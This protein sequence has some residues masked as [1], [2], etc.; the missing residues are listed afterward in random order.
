MKKSL[1]FVAAVLLV[2]GAGAQLRDYKVHKRGMLHQSVFNTGELGRAYD[3]GQGGSAAGVPS[4]E[5]PGYSSVI[6][7]NVSYNGQ[8]HSF[9]AGIYLAVSR[10]DTSSRLFSHCGAVEEPVAGRYAFPLQL[11]RVE[12]YPVLP[13]GELN[14]AFNPDEAEEIITAKWATNVGLTVTRVSRAWSMPDYDDLIIYEYE[15]EHT[16]DVDGDPATPAFSVPLTDVLVAFDYL[17]APSMFGYERHYNRWDGADFGY[18]GDLAPQYPAFNRTRWLTYGRDRT[19]QPE[20]KYFNEWAP[21]AKYGGGL[22][23]AQVPGFLML[24][25][26]TTH[27]AYKTETRVQVSGSDSLI[28][29]DANGHLKQ[30]F[31]NRQETAVMSLGKVQPYMD[32]NYPRKNNPYRDS[33]AFGADWRGRGSYNWRQSNYFGIGHILIFGPYTMN[34]GDKIRFSIAEVAG[35]G[36]ARLEETQAGLKDEGGS[37]GENCGEPTSPATN[38]FQPVANWYQPITYGGADGKARVHGSDYLS[39]YPLPQYVNSNVV[40]VREVADQAIQMYT[41]GALLDYDTLQYWPDRAPDRGVYRSPISIHAPAIRISSTSKA[42]NEIAWGAQM[43]SFTAPRLVG[44][45]S[46][47]E[48]WKSSHPLGPWSRLDSVGRG[49]PRYFAEGIY[50]L[51]DKNTRVG[52]SFYYSVLSVDTK[53]NKSGRTNMT[54]HQTQLGGTSTLEKVYVVPNPFVVR[55]G[56]TGTTA[57]GG[58]AGS[59]IGFYNLPKK[60]TIRV[61][62]YSGQLVETIEHSSE[63]YSTEYLQV[64][65]NNQ[66]IASGVYFYVVETPDGTRTHGKF[67]VIH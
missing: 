13:S 32:M 67:V 54:L 40:T 41:G 45:L 31:L 8:Y 5:W 24:H 55:S 10:Q 26:D 61:V 3:R 42:E 34:R 47:Y 44:P 12:N 2:Q 37:C 29:W 50:K 60:C 19:G 17:L 4:F 49:D 27:L 22:L 30:P 7:D 62:S 65:R 51:I 46:H 23:S 63:L 36:A 39:N 6:V 11:T 25:Y 20:P 1:V 59:K 15:I 33:A 58:D 48:V 35:Y 38:A 64:T 43:E 18:R 52:E 14:P 21:T 53:G 28:V 9:G 56:Y 66:L 57:T 16:G